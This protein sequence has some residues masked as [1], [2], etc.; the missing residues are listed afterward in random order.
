[1]D[2]PVRQNVIEE[3]ISV[4]FG[5][6]MTLK[7]GIKVKIIWGIQENNNHLWREESEGNLILGAFLIVK[8][9]APEYANKFTERNVSYKFCAA[10]FIK[11]SIQ[12]T[13]RLPEFEGSFVWFPQVS[14]SLPV[15]AGCF[16]VRRHCLTVPSDLFSWY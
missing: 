2:R 3:N 1:M 16:G 8:Y 7:Y 4:T 15:L 12:N 11:Y 5:R 10:C 14:V 9:W 6:G 13:W